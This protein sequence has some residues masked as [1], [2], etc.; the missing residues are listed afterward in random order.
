MPESHYN[1][2]FLKYDI[3]C[4]QNLQEKTY[5]NV[6]SPTMYWNIII[7]KTRWV[8]D[9]KHKFQIQFMVYQRLCLYWKTSVINA[10]QTA[11]FELQN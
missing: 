6:L 9:F 7:K 5:E 1:I 11:L 10:P 2:L 3:A 4:G 8:T